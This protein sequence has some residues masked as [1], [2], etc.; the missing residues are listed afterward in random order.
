M[1]G[2]GVKT[3][4]YDIPSHH[5]R[6]REEVQQLLNQVKEEKEKLNN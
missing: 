3:N 4:T 1:A 5:K 2:K 6:Q